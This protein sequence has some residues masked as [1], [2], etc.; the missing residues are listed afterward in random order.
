MVPTA[1]PVHLSQFCDEDLVALAKEADF[2]PAA[3]DLMQRFYQRI[4]RL[5]AR[6]ARQ[7]R[8]PVSDLPDAQQN[9]ILAVTEAVACYDPLQYDRPGGC[10]FRHFLRVVVVARFRD[11]VRRNRRRQQH[12]DPYVDTDAAVE[13]GATAP[14]TPVP[15]WLL[16]PARTDPPTAALRQEFLARLDQA[17]TRCEPRLRRLW[18]RLVAGAKLRVIAAELGVSYY[19]ARRL[20]QK[21]LAE[22]THELRGLAPAP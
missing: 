6:L 12:H 22:L 15:R 16:D 5:I 9:G 14:A 1:N 2:S 17:L 18:E 21:L 20:R 7:C 19:A 13:R 3:H 4:N 8:L 10:S 11:F